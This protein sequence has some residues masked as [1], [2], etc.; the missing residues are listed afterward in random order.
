MTSQY[1]A[2]VTAPDE[3]ALG[4]FD[5]GGGTPSG[6]VAAETSFGIA[7]AAGSS[8]D[9]S[10]GDHTHGT[11]T[12]PVTAHDAD[13]AA[14]PALDAR[15]DALEAASSA[16]PDVAV[17][18]GDY[19]TIAAALSAGARNVRVIDNVTLTSQLLINVS[20]VL[21]DFD[22]DITVTTNMASATGNA[23]IR[24]LGTGPGSFTNFA[25]NHPAG[26]F[27][28]TV[29]SSHGLVAGDYIQIESTRD[30]MGGA[31]SFP[32]RAKE[33]L[34]ILSVASTT[35]TVEQACL[36]AYNTAQTAR[37]AKWTPL[38]NVRLRFNGC[39][40][41]TQTPATQ[42]NYPVRFDYVDGGEV[43][44]IVN[45]ISHGIMIYECRRVNIKAL[46]H[47]DLVARNN[48]GNE[49]LAY[50]V[51]VAAGSY[52]CT[53]EDYRCADSQHAFTTLYEERSGP[54]YYAG[55]YFT[56]VM[57]AFASGSDNNGQGFDT[58]G[59]AYSTVF[60]NCKVVGH[61]VGGFTNRGYYTKR[62]ACSAIRTGGDAFASL[63]N[64]A[65]GCENID[66]IAIDNAF[67]GFVPG[68]GERIRGG[69]SSGGGLTGAW[70]Y[71]DSLAPTDVIFDGVLFKENNGHAIRFDGTVKAADVIIKNCIAPQ[72][73]TQAASFVLVP[74]SA[75]ITG[76]VLRGYG[77]GDDGITGSPGSYVTAN[78]VDT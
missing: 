63:K 38:R 49:S 34:K 65:Y 44:G 52:H 46:D 2:I 10:R 26:T 57:N 4:E 78:L 76:N 35:V 77:S 42:L 50:G 11:P 67:E 27:T 61:N 41:A 47:H 68:D 6:T 71:G 9:Y 13:A 64:E 74:A 12:N 53:V 60:F 51:T 16:T 45:A 62:I 72:S 8:D 1:A 25:G 70:I 7:S 58:H 20:D 17:V 3:T 32:I 18:P 66:C 15:L 29:G 31:S 14:H 21:I 55:P 30:V 48:G 23:A 75:M 24:A 43:T 59:G 56:T 39:R 40:V 19:A 22:P 33:I 73:A 37:W 69:E 5:G 36:W 28:F 54:V